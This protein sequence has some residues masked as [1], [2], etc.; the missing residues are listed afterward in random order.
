MGYRRRFSGRRRARKFGGPP[1]ISALRRE[2]E[3]TGVKKCKLDFVMVAVQVPDG[4]PRRDRRPSPEDIDLY[5]DEVRYQLKR[6]RVY[7]SLGHVPVTKCTVVLLLVRV[8]SGYRK[9]V[10]RVFSK[11]GVWVQV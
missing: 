5:L 4:D 1:S 7:P 2:M 8:G 6:N 3:D 11:R 9:P 10:M